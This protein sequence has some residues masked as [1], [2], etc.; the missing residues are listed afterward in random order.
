ME[1]R[2]IV[3]VKLSIIAERTKAKQAKIQ[4]KR[5]LFRVLINLILKRLILL[6]CLNMD[7]HLLIFFIIGDQ[8]LIQ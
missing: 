5:T 4:S 6:D 3:A 8:T 7:S 1:I 2:T